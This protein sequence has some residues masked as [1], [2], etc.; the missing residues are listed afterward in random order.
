VIG[1]TSLSTASKVRLARA[2]YRGVVSIRS[3]AHLPMVVVARRRAVQFELD[4]GEAIDLAMYLGGAFEFDTHRALRRFV[5]NGHTVVDIGANSGVHTLPLARMV[6]ERGRVIA[7]EPTDYAFQ[8]LLRNLELNPDISGRVTPVLAYLDDGRDADAPSSFYASWKLE[9][10]QG[11]HP[12]HFGSL[13]GAGRATAWTLDDYSKANKVRQVAVIKLDVDG[14]ECKVLRGASGLIKR[15]RPVIIAE[16]CPYALEEH[17]GSAEEM[18]GLLSG[19]GYSFYDERTLKPLPS[20]PRRLKASIKHNSSINI[21]AL[22]DSGAASFRPPRT[23]ETST[24]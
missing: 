11:Q 7:F 21:V 3:V 6:G 19:H 18:L 24:G 12:K 2:L 22:A 10:T 8:R 1:W 23:G 13:Q 15:D 17:D 14:F 20:D 16:I 4:L 5:R 9:V